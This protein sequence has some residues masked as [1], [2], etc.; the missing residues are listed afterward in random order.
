MSI[1]F[2][3]SLSICTYI[4]ILYVALSLCVYLSPSHTNIH[5][6]YHCIL[7][8][9]YVYIYIYI[10][11]VSFVFLYLHIL[12]SLPSLLH[13]YIIYRFR[14]RI[15]SLTHFSDIR[16]TC[17]I[18]R[19]LTKLRRF[20]Y[21]ARKPIGNCNSFMF[22]SNSHWY[23]AGEPAAAPATDAE[24]AKTDKPLEGQQD[25]SSKEEPTKPPVEPSEPSKPAEAGAEAS[26][27]DAPAPAAAEPSAETPAA[28]APAADAPA[29][30]SPAADA[31]SARRARGTCNGCCSGCTSRRCTSRGTSWIAYGGRGRR[32]RYWGSCRS[33]TGIL[34]CTGRNTRRGTS[35]TSGGNCRMR[36]NQ[37][38]YLQRLQLSSR[39]FYCFPFALFVWK[40]CNINIICICFV[41]GLRSLLIWY[42]R[43]CLVTSKCLQ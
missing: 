8:Y 12:T 42:F 6:S 2:P 35:S 34:R 20:A 30:D 43:L 3:L 16:L 22:F 37:R 19:R 23:E 27:A 9:M 26:A 10:H 24:G 5:I 41:K 31:P 25:P 17:Q 32:G 33:S 11:T 29:A 40:V 15:T 28:D 21:L 36:R 1:F 7:V 38:P 18:P 4:Y 13:R 14:Y 39:L